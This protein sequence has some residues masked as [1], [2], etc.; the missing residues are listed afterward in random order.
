M[1]V[2]LFQQGEPEEK[3]QSFCSELLAPYRK[4]QTLLVNS[5]LS[6]APSVATVMCLAQGARDITVLDFSCAG[7]TPTSARELARWLMTLSAPR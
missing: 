1:C 3:F 4:G 7:L 2:E 6:S 5:H